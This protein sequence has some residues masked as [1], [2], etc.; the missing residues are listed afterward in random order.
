MSTKHISAVT[1]GHISTV[2]FKPFRTDVQI[3]LLWQNHCRNR[4]YIEDKCKARSLT[5]L[6]C[7]SRVG[8]VWLVMRISKRV[9]SYLHR[10]P[11]PR[12]WVVLA[13]LQ[14]MRDEESG[15]LH[16]TAN[17][18]SSHNC[19]GVSQNSQWVAAMHLLQFPLWPS[20]NIFMATIKWCFHA[21]VTAK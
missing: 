13:S 3:V 1:I 17:E 20:S 10:R 19:Y 15:P 14:V 8:V 2:I 16:S 7:G 12:R 21:T 9:L 4:Y 6:Y 11:C 18:Q 5:R